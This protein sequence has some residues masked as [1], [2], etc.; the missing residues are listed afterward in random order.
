MLC[1][2]WSLTSF[3]KSERFIP[4]VGLVGS[5]LLAI[6]AVR[7]W[8]AAAS[9]APFEDD[10]AGLFTPLTVALVQPANPKTWISSLSYRPGRAQPA[11]RSPHRCC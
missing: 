1:A 6:M 8:R 9:A 2:I 11:S 7:Q 5:M 10:P 4:Y 3:S